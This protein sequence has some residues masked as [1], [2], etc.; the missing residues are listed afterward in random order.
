MREVEW[1]GHQSRLDHAVVAE[2]FEP[3]DFDSD[4]VFDE[5][6]F[7]EVVLQR[8]GSGSVSAVKRRDGQQGSIAGCF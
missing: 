3:F 4:A 5:S 1:R 2:E 6:E 7:G 8:G